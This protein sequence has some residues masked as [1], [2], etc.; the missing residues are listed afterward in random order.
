MSILFP[1]L[2]GIGFGVFLQK[3]RFCFVQAF[4][5]LFAYKD[6]RMIKG[7]IAAVILTMFFWSIAYELGTYQGLWLP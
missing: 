6:T 4:R 5:D 7:V 3:G 2:I 1:A